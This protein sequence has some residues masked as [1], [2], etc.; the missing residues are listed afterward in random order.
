MAIHKNLCPLK[1]VTIQYIEILYFL[2]LPLVSTQDYGRRSTTLSFRRCDD[3]SCTSV[4]ITND[5]RV[6]PLA[7]TFSVALSAS[8]ADTRITV[9]THPSTVVIM[10]D[11]GMLNGKLHQKITISDEFRTYEMW[12]V[13][14]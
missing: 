1:F 5:A 3:R 6:E 12:G 10:D 11:D 13:L 9:N 2:F 4:S 8:S 14:G 7:E